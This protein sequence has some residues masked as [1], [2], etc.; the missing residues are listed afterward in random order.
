MHHLKPWRLWIALCLMPFVASCGTAVEIADNPPPPRP[1]ATL[2]RPTP[3]PTGDPATLRDMV[4]MVLDY[5]DSL[6]QC[7]ADKDAISAFYRTLGEQTR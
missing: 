1:P 4:R 6:G 5:S 7:N 3:H 2:L